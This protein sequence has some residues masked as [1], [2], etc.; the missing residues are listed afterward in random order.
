MFKPGNLS[1][2]SHNLCVRILREYNTEMG[3]KT[4]LTDG[5]V[6]CYHFRRGDRPVLFWSLGTIFSPQSHIVNTNIK[7]LNTPGL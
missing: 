5:Q 2:Q 1:T 4:F 3:N 7:A 6:L